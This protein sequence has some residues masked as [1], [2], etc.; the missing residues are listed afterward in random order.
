[1]VKV[2]VVAIIFALIIIYLKSINSEI[3]F[4]ATIGCSILIMLLAIE[5][6]STAV[7]F[8][9]NLIEKSGVDNE[10]VV[11]IFKILAIG[12]LVEFSAQTVKDFGLVSLA[13]KLIFVGK[14]VIFCVS[15]PILYSLFN[16]LIGFLQ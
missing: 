10:L 1:M 9:K 15:I 12:Y 16:L 2:V 3:A 5:Y 8:I 14:L 11:I 6:L 13:D 4:L 7:D